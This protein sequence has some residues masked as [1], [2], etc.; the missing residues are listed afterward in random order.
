MR[1]ERTVN[2]RTMR[3]TYAPMIMLM[4]AATGNNYNNNNNNNNYYSDK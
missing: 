4:I 2:S 1:M 3:T